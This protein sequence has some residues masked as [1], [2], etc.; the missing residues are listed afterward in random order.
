MVFVGQKIVGIVSEGSRNERQS[1]FIIACFK[2]QAAKLRF[3]FG[4]FWTKFKDFGENRSGAFGLP[5]LF[6]NPS[7][8]QT[9]AHTFPMKFERV[10][11]RFDRVVPLMLSCKESGQSL[12]QGGGI[13]MRGSRKRGRR[14]RRL[15]V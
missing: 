3:R 9:R 8:R 1:L 7:K 5:H 6:V 14:V 2:S 15:R 4:V 10:P 11:V 12:P 13:R